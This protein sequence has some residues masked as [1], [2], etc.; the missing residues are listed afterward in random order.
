LPLTLG[1]IDGKIFRPLAKKNTV[2]I[3]G[4]TAGQKTGIALDAKLVHRQASQQ[5]PPH[6]ALT[7]QRET[8]QLP[9]DQRFD[10]TVKIPSGSCS[11][12]VT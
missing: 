12:G 2:E 5:A 3:Q 7:P 4:D 8:G 11:K 6:L 1:E 9:F 10:Q